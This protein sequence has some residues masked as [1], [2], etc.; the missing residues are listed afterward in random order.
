MFGRIQRLHQAGVLG[1]N[2]R[3]LE[4]IFGYNPRHYYPLVDDKLQTK[5]L[6]ETAGIPIPPL[7]RVIE[8]QYQVKQLAS[9]LAPYADFVIKPAHGSG[10]DGI[11]VVEQQHEQRYRKVN[12]E[13]MS[14]FALQHHVS[15]ILGG[16]YSL[17][18]QTDH[19]LVEYRIQFDPVFAAITYQGVPDV[20]I[21]VFQ[22]FPVMAML[23]LPTRQS[24]G[25]ANLHQGA[26]GVGIDIATGLTTS[27]V[28][29][30]TNIEEHPETGH[31]LRGVRVPHWDTM[32]L[33]AARCFELAGLGYV[34]A[35]FVLDKDKGPLLLELNARPGLNIQIANRAG[36]LPR[37]RHVQTEAPALLNPEQRVA[38]ARQHLGL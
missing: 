14:L 31:A 21:I 20:R 25:K 10:G 9:L 35:D 18:G 4:F 15:S 34:G 8:M 17:G 30:N 36:L 38:F 37:L 3:N 26:V 16:L 22:G 1:M 32:L 7:Y 29:A 2:R 19:A 23:R 6:A 12:G 11:V 24:Q 5:H 13:V 28:H 33:T 27:A